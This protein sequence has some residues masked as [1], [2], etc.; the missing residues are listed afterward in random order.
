LTLLWSSSLYYSPYSTHIETI[1]HLESAD[2]TDIPDVS[3]D[4]NRFNDDSI[5]LEIGEHVFFSDEEIDSFVNRESLYKLGE[6][7]LSFE[8]FDD[9]KYI[10]SYTFMVLFEKGR[11]T[12]MLTDMFFGNNKKRY[13]ASIF[14]QFKSDTVDEVRKLLDIR[15]WRLNVFFFE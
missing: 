11:N 2:N 12:R 7:I 4:M 14:C 1:V 8:H 6:I 3:F 10:I 9:I 15:S 5:I 13:F